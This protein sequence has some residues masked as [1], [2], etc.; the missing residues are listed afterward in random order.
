TRAYEA[1]RR[2]RLSRR[3]T[4]ARARACAA[5][6]AEAPDPRRADVGA[7]AAGGRGDHAGHQ[8]PERGGHH[9]SARGA[10][11]A[12]GTLGRGALLRAGGR[13]GRIFGDAG[14][15]REAPAADEGLSRRGDGALTSHTSRSIRQRSRGVFTV[16]FGERSA[17]SAAEPTAQGG[18]RRRRPR[19]ALTGSADLP[20]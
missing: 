17:C 18:P 16:T 12:P 15:A 3:A 14:G 4:Q 7:R 20:V 13:P 11:R 6:T 8:A 1:A 5:V 9:D 10:E 19:L 2:H